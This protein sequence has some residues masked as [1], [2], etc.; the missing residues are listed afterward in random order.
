M[1]NPMVKVFFTHKKF[2]PTS[3]NKK[4]RDVGLGRAVVK[5]YRTWTINQSRSYFA[6]RTIAWYDKRMAA[7]PRCQKKVPHSP[8]TIMATGMTMVML[9][10]IV[11]PIVPS[12]RRITWWLF[13]PDLYFNFFS[14]NN[15]V[16]ALANFYPSLNSTLQFVQ[17]MSSLDKQL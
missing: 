6:A 13:N 7:P 15:K 10:A 3:D 8:T 17:E 2:R 14:V 11:Q 9:Q 1:L 12:R 5:I 4:D 16:A